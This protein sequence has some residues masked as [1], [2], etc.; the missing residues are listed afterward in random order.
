MLICAAIFVG[1]LW[2]GCDVPPLSRKKAWNLVIPCSITAIGAAAWF[3]LIQVLVI[4]KLCPS[5]LVSHGLVLIATGLLLLCAPFGSRPDQSAP[6]MKGSLIS[7]GRATRHLL[8]ALMAL[9]LLV[10]G[11]TLLPKETHV[12]KG[13]A[14]GVS[15][16]PQS[17][18]DRR[19]QILDGRFRFDLRDVPLIGVPEAPNVIVSLLD[20]T[21]FACRIMHA[22]LTEV[23][24]T[25]SN[26]LAIVFLPMPLDAACNPSVTNTYPA[27]SN[28]CEYARIGLALWRANREAFGRFNQWMYS[29]PFVPKLTEARE[30]AR[31]LAGPEAFDKALRDDWINEQLKRDVAIYE[32]TCAKIGENAM[33]QLIIGT[34]IIFG[35]FSRQERLY[36]LLA[37]QLGLK[38]D[39]PPP[40]V[41]PGQPAPAITIGQWLKGGP[42]DFAAAKGKN[43]YVLVFWETGCDACM[44]ALP[45]LTDLQRKFSDQSVIVIG[46]TEE[47]APG[48]KA[49]LETMGGKLD[50][51]VATDDQHK[52]YEAYRSAIGESVPRAFVI[53]K[54]GTIAW[55]GF[56]IEGLDQAVAEIVAGS[57]DIE[58]AKRAVHAA[59][60]QQQYFALVMDQEKGSTGAR[61]GNQILE[62]SGKNPWLLNNFAWEI[63]T[64]SRIKTR[65][66][67]LALRAAKQAYETTKGN[68]APFTDTYAR[69][70]FESGQV[71]QAIRLQRKA[72]ETCK[73]QGLRDQLEAT[74]K[75]YLDKGK[76]KQAP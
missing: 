51:I 11:Q 27:H 60:L 26:Q 19:L 53:D 64:D 2:L 56:P 10:A 58:L 12:V 8:A 29:T 3:F 18:P 1:T 5:C 67:D 50:F 71:D 20:Y 48:V 15:V 72:I 40:A 57:F 47:P 24:K 22:Q 39:L 37:D 43:V 9:G 23:Q 74:L 13:V 38:G 30:A 54:H 73:D 52:T 16:W 36:R 7:A 44:A 65:D 4:K 28:A 6:D 49:F 33:P 45:G 68:E 61:L 75:L 46:I 35:S 31:G 21:C 17:G 42:V 62:G 25:F 76:A 41:E 69:A 32:T 59:E 55:Q 70:L 34:N 63:L 66:L 14:S